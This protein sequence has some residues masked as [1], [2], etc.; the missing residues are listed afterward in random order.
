MANHAYHTPICLA[1]H[2]AH[3]VRKV[4]YQQK[5]M[6]KAAVHE[7]EV[8]QAQDATTALP[9]HLGLPPRHGQDA[10]AQ[11]GVG[12][13]GIGCR[14]GAGDVPVEVHEHHP[15]GRSLEQ[16]VEKVVLLPQLQAFL[17]QLV[18]HPVEECHDTVG[19][20]IGHRGQPTGKLLLL[21][22]V[23]APGNGTHGTHGIP[24]QQYDHHSHQCRHQ[25]PSR[26]CR[27]RHHGSGIW[28][29]SIRR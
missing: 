15:H 8:A 2:L 13:Q 11:Q 7:G 29:F 17:A 14:I 12:Q 18:H 25:Q 23:H 9:Q 6:V 3:L 24:P 26:V 5:R 19:P 1:L 10:R 27:N 20:R 21:Q 4:L 28:C 16:E 22:Q